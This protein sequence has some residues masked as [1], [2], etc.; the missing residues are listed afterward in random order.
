MGL[1]LPLL[2]AALASCAPSASGC[3]ICDP[4]VEAEIKFLT[5]EYLP[6]RMSSKAVKSFM[7]KFTKEVKSFSQVRLPDG[8]YLGI[9]DEFFEKDIFGMLN[10]AKLN[11]ANMT[12]EFQS[13]GTMLQ[14]VTQCS[15]CEK[16]I[17]TCEKKD[18]ICADR[19]MNVHETDDLNLDCEMN[20]HK[21]SQG[22]TL[23]RFF[24]VWPN[25]TETLESQGK[26]SV[27]TKYWVE[28]Q[29]AGTYRC[30]LGLVQN[31]TA[32][33]MFFRVHV[34]PSKVNVE[35]P[36]NVEFTD[37]EYWENEEVDQGPFQEEG[38]QQPSSA[39]T[40]TDVQ[41]PPL[42]QSPRHILRS[43]LLGLLGWSAMALVASIAIAILY[44]HSG[45][46]SHFI[47]ASLFGGDSGH[48]KKH[49]VSKKKKK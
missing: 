37:S 36:V 47:K 17:R 30:E 4:R 33:V 29:D 49:E 40:T 25:N 10:Q 26:H 18:L 39:N 45:K 34:L 38:P 7:D 42:S 3:L 23:Y 24:K 21:L 14:A 11:F 19:T 44:F 22:L 43:R 41:I 28:P 8:P 35:H 32:S 5:S 31:R 27:L 12:A 2:V 1:R 6:T 16:E 15:K 48:K 13:K 9:L 20:W 46:V